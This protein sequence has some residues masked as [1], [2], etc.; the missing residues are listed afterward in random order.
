MFRR[1]E[2]D[3][4][5]RVFKVCKALLGR[6]IHAKALPAPFGNWM[7]RRVLEQLRGAPFDPGV[8]RLR[9]AR[10]ELLNEPRLAEPRLA[11]DQHDLAFAGPDAVPSPLQQSQFLL[12]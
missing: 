12:A 5:Q 7:K 11:H 4:S 9:E 3:Q 10:M 2:A 8:G 6:R 1:V